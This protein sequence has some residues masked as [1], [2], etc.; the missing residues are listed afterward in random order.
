MR[1]ERE[2]IPSK[3]A[4]TQKDNLIE[5]G[6][7]RSVFGKV[8]IESIKP[9]LVCV[10][11]DKRGEQAKARANREQA[12]LSQ[13]FNKARE[14]GYAGAP[15]PCQGVKG[16]TES[17]RDRCVTDAEFQAVWAQADVTVQDAMDIVSLTDQ[18][19]ADVLKI[20]RADISDGALLIAQNK[21]RAKRAIESIGELAV[22]IARI[23]KRHRRL[24][25]LAKAAR[26]QEPR[27]DRALCSR[28]HRTTGEAAAV[29]LRFLC[30]NLGI[31]Q[32][33]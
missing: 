6:R 2:V 4:R 5:L 19:P 3:A 15:N 16:F 32:T 33:L 21:R 28:A 7:L 12:L 20:R 9:H 13:L 25:P 22:L 31:S 17:Q 23:Q 24:G 10:Y 14:R 27:H 26:A 18:R 30:R 11:L 29:G 1:Y 8:L